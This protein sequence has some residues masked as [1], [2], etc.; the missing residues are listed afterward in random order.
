MTSSKAIR[1]FKSPFS[2]KL[3]LIEAS[4]YT[5]WAFIIIH[6][7][8]F[9]KYLNWLDNPKENNISE[10][11]LSELARVIR[12]ID[13][14]AFWKTT[15]YTQAI[16]ARLILKRKKIKSQIFL[17]MTKDTDGKLL[18]HAWTKVGDQT[19]TGGNNTDKYKVLYTFD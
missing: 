18:A 2:H 1:F 15:C 11:T 5:I 12:Q 7:V 9:K 19:I 14:Y 6:T 13:K 17:G 3:L 10:K 8:S 16:A 4:V